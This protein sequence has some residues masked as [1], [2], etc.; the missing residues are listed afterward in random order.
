MTMAIYPGTFDPFTNGHRDVALRASELFDELIVAVFDTPAKSLLF[1]TEERVG[2]IRNSMEDSANVHVRP[3]SGLTV[4]FATDVGAK[5]IIRGLRSIS[6]F[7]NE[8]AM[9]MMNRKMHS[10]ITTIYMTT[11]TEFTFVSSTLIKEVARLGGN[12]ND[13]VPVN[14]AVAL[15]G[16]YSFQ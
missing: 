3:Y 9:D 11:G 2:F 1:T 15:Q 14:V 8:F 7:D 6:D 4:D 10:E 5:A 13:F 16:K 12:I